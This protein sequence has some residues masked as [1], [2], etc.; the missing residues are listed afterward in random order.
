M[1]ICGGL[2]QSSMPTMQAVSTLAS[3]E[4]ARDDGTEDA[5]S[6]IG[7]TPFVPA[8]KRQTPSYA[9]CY[10]KTSFFSAGEIGINVNLM[11]PR[12]ACE[13]IVSRDWYGTWIPTARTCFQTFRCCRVV[14]GLLD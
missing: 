1:V 6:L 3:L 7:Y 8:D 11:T 12:C 4:Y 14:D 2:A 13:G 10:Q 5:K 9:T